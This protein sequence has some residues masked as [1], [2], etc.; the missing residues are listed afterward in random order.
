MSLSGAPLAHDYPPDAGVIA[1]LS[2]RLADALEPAHG[3]RARHRAQ[4]K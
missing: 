1:A 4:Q 3:F 2:E